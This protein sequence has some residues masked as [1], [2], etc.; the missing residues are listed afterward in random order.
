MCVSLLQAR[1]LIGEVAQL[2]G[3]LPHTIEVRP[4]TIEVRLVEGRH[5]AA[6]FSISTS[7][8]P[9]SMLGASCI[10]IRTYTLA[11]G[12]VFEFLISKFS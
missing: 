9:A 4:Q 11:M 8:M 2:S 3:G 1:G 10:Y 5:T 12:I 7:N 6:Q